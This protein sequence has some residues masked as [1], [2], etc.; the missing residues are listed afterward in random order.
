MKVP[1]I[2]DDSEGQVKTRSRL[3]SSFIGWLRLWFGLRDEVGPLAYAISGCGLMLV[4]YLA[5][6]GVIAFA[7]GKFYSPISFL[8]PFAS[9]RI[10][11]HTAQF[12][13]IAP[14]L[15]L[16]SLPFF[17]IAL[18]MSVRRAADAGL[19]PWYGLLVM[20]PFLN[21]IFMISLAGCNLYAALG[22]AASRIAISGNGA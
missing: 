17:W 13:W 5:E 14:A 8:L 12:D 10:P 20:I 4:K 1:V 16:G 22:Q 21:F 11:T 2:R 19:P 7:T 18:S 15:L 3:S 9:V 6:F